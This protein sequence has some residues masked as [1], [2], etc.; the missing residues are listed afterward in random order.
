M[1]KRKSWIWLALLLVTALMFTACAAPA[2]P[3]AETADEPASEEA[4]GEAAEEAP[5]ESAG[6]GA[7]QIP[8]IEEG[9]FNVA[10]VYVGPV[11]DGGWTYAHNE[12]REY[13]EAELGDQWRLPTWKA[14]PKALTQNA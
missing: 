2:A 13:L 14:C 8:E 1:Q 12:G 5:A 11:G 9:K 10:F 4:A 6:A 3:S 7:I